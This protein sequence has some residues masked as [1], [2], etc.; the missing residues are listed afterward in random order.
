MLC[1]TRSL[2]RWINYSCLPT[3]KRCKK[4]FKWYK[5]S[6]EQGNPIAQHNLVVMYCFG[7]GILKNLEKC[8]YWAEEAEKNGMDTSHLRDKFELWKHK[9]E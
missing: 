1:K 7:I 4:A 9:E 8:S 6:A 2:Q 3:H 5:K